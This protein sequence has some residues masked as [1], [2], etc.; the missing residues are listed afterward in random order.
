LIETQNG[1]K[2]IPVPIQEKLLQESCQKELRGLAP[3]GIMELWSNGMMGLK[4]FFTI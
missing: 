4:E 2:G 1:L 3:I